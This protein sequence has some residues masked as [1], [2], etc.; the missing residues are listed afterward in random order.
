[1]SVT[2][3][4]KIEFRAAG[5]GRLLLKS[6]QHVNAFSELCDVQD[7]ML[8]LGVN[9]NFTYTSAHVGHWFPIIWDEAGLKPV[10]LVT[11][12]LPNTDRK[13]P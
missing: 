13:R 10:K 11:G 6:V 7:S 8:C 2:P 3:S 12:P 9:P 1:M 4:A 5:P